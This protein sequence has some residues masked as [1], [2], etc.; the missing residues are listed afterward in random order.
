MNRLIKACIA[1]TLL[2]LLL[3]NVQAKDSLK[4]LFKNDFKIG[5]S[6]NRSQFTG[7]DKTS[8]EIVK[9]E[10]NTISPENELK[11]ETIHPRLGQ[12][13]FRFADQ[14]VRFGEENGMEII[15]HTLVWHNQTPKE[16]FQDSTG[17]PIGRAELLSR[18]RDHIY[19]VVGR[20]KGR[21]DGWDVVNEAL[22]EDGTLRQSPWMKIIGEDYIAKAF[23]FANE[24][25]PKAK[26]FYNDYS[27]ENA[28][29]RR[30]AIR[31]IKDL[32]KRGVKIDGIGTQNHNDLYFPS[33]QQ[34]DETLNEFGKLGIEVM[35]TEL[36]MN[37]LPNP[38]GFGGGAE[39]TDNFENRNRLNPYTNGLPKEIQ[40]RQKDRYIELFEVYKKHA[41]S[42]SRVTFWNV[43]D[44]E[45][46]LNHFPVKGRTNY[47]LLFDRKGGK[48][49]AYFGLFERFSRRP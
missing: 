16:V 28:P 22:N 8:I 30:G 12:Y 49:T 7:Q 4:E 45:S 39:I 2:G 1:M 23:Q 10:F 11:W 27:L 20:Y 37:V 24:A 17:K 40:D 9:K 47:P 18:M 15:G 44:K 48:K 29:K 6:L 21:I 42:I 38:K 5:A 13:D 32:Q 33:R 14:Y 36:D 34:L 46:W 35:I 31:L 3:G 43:T 41:D 25:D 26:L 19:T